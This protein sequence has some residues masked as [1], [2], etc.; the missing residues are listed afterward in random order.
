MILPNRAF[1]IITRYNHTRT[2]KNMYQ[3]EIDGQEFWIPGLDVAVYRMASSTKDFVFK[4]IRPYPVVMVINYD[5]TRG[6][7]EELFVLSHEE[8]RGELRYIGSK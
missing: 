8:D 4:N 7:Q 6:G 3:N 5:G 1:E 2:Y